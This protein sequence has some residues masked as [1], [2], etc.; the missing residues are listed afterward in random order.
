MVPVG[1]EARESEPVSAILKNVT[2]SYYLP[3]CPQGISVPG[4]NRI[5]YENMY[6]GID[7]HY[8]GASAGQ[9]LA[10]V[11]RPGS[12][13]TK[14]K[15]QFTGQDSLGLDVN[16]FL[17]L[18]SDGKYLTLPYALAYQVDGGGT[19]EILGWG[20]T[21]NADNDAGTIGFYYDSY[22]TSKPLILLIGSLPAGVGGGEDPQPSWSTLLGT[23]NGTGS[24]EFIS[25]GDAD[26]EGN[27]YVAGNTRDQAFPISTGLTLHAGN[28][29][30]IYGK[31]NYAP[32]NAGEDARVSY[33]VF[34]GGTGN[35]KATIL[36]CSRSAEDDVMYIA[37][38]TNSLRF[39]VLPFINPNDGGF[40]QENRKGAN[41]GFV[42]KANL[43][44]GEV[45]R[46][47]YFGGEGTEMVTAVAEDHEGNMYFGGA[48]TSATGVFGSDCSSPGTGFPL[49][50]VEIADYQQT[51]NAGGT[52]GFIFRL[53]QGFRLTWSTFYG[54][55]GDD[56][57]YDATYM[58]SPDLPS[59][60]TDRIA[61]V[62]SS[63]NSVP[64]GTSGAFQILAN[65][66]E[67]GFICT[68]DSD[69]R[70]QWGTMI[71]G[72]MRLEAVI[73]AK[74]NLIV[75]GYTDERAMTELTCDEVLNGIP[76][77]TLG[78]A[79][80]DATIQHRD[81]FFAEFVM[82]SGTLE[83]STV[84]GDLGW[85]GAEFLDENGGADN[86]LIEQQHPFP[87]YRFSDLEADALGNLFAM[88]LYDNLD[89]TH[90][91]NRIDRQEG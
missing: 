50:S 23:G 27:L 19:P 69:G 29:D 57:I 24:S 22:D 73:S 87:I 77:C 45:E 10:I 37:G 8:Y 44:N 2:Y 28:D 47:T 75:M 42:I 61:F 21:Y 64:F 65:S 68:F 53:D 33:L 88:G 46:S 82:P 60:P 51:E 67:N 32:G 9:K 89:S 52:D 70:H 38:W 17:K 80:S 83:W 79:Y 58:P 54:G 6:D 81:A 1:T 34:F 62:G 66:S 3:H 18:H 36:H 7:F 48:T 13:P 39:P 72:L 25:A 76:I 56:H 15:L 86:Y 43:V 40:R 59:G 4:Y 90:K 20:A 78:T 84:Y 74:T 11:C 16:G 85:M 49:C 31:F 71:H 26:N 63:T 55:I 41:D 30:V 91:R 35:D 12:D 5:I 14:I